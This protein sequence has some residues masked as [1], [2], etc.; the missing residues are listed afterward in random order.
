M[1][2]GLL[3]SGQRVVLMPLFKSFADFFVMTYISH[4]QGLPPNFTFGCYEDTPRIKLFD[5]WL[6][7]CGYIFS[8]RA[9]DQSL[10][11]N[12]TNSALLRE[13]IDNNQLTTVFQNGFRYRSGK[14]SRKMSPD[15]SIRWLL[16]AF[17]SFSKVSGKN[18]VIVPVVI[19][20][21]RKFES[22][23]I[24]TEMVSGSKRDYTMI[25]SM[26]KL[27]STEEDSLGQV[28]VKY[29]DP[30]NVADWVK[31]NTIQA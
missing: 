8:R 23:N 9:Q 27:Y 21:D 20:Y 18:M 10:S 25:T 2:K 1:V 22:G 24:A 16:D 13:L 7:R 26:H 11:S 19:S 3:A 15:M 17:K 4:T 31:E 30:V 29:L 6:N 14:L 12:Y 28:Y 5:A